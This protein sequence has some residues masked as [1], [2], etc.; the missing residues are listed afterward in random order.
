ME[1]SF[2]FKH[3]K[4]LPCCI[5]PNLCAL[6]TTWQ[7]KRLIKTDVIELCSKERRHTKLRFYKFPNSTV[8]AVLLKNELMGCKYTAS[9]GPL[10]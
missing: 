10:L 7:A 4:T 1:D 5:N 3:T 6:R 2:V 8:F 9:P